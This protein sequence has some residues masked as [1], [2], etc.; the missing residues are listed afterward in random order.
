M[1]HQIAIE[2]VL[3]EK[4]LFEPDPA[5]ARRANVPGQAAYR[6]LR[7]EAETDYQRYW[8]RL[9][10]EHVDWFT[11]WKKVLDWKPPFAKWFVGAKTNISYNC[12]DRHLEGPNAW[13]RNKAAIIWE[14]E[15]GDQRVLTFGD[16]HRE[17][18]KCANVLKGLGVKK[19]DRVAIYMPM[20]PELAVAML[21]CTRIGAVHSII[22]GGFSADSIRDRVNDAKAKLVITADGGWRRGQIIPLKDTIDEALQ[23]A[24]S[25][26][27]VLVVQRTGQSIL[28]KNGR[29]QWWHDQMKTAS[30]DC[31]PAKLDAEHPLFILYTSGTTGKPK[32]I[33]H[34]TGGYLVHTTVTAKYIFDLKEEDTYWCT[35]DIGWVTGHSYVIYG[36]LS[37][38]VTSVMYEGAPNHPDVDRF[39]EIVDKYNVTILYTAPTAIR[40]FMKW[41]D[42]HVRKH[43]L[44]SLRLL[45]TVGEP[46]NP[47]AWIWYH[48]TLGKKRCPIVDTWWQTE[49]GGILITPLPGC[50][51][52]TP[53]SATLP[54]PGIFA[55]ILDEQGKPVGTNQG[56]YLVIT[57]PWPGMLRGIYGDRKRYKEQY[58]SKYKGIYLTG[59]GARKDK[60]GY[61]WI[62]GR[63][64]DVMNVAGHRLS[65]MEIESA[66]VSHPEV[67]EAAVVGR[68]DEIKGTAIVGFVTL[69]QGNEPSDALRQTLRQHVAKEIGAIARPD[70]IRFTES[71]PKTRSGKIMR[72]LLRDIA[73]GRGSVGDTTTLEDYSILAKLREAEEA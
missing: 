62:M 25:V 18:C 65:T 71:L 30:S 5:F 26:K 49:T 47:E 41:G 31:P 45:G 56:G 70:E 3:R 15:P 29:D 11:P 50:V 19:G 17:V 22:F 72:R 12:L 10:K 34:T 35:A 16:L 4:R 63:V 48:R 43:S 59:D 52:T 40:T 21:A 33:L 46:I 42:K 27:H 51:T 2:S 66:L 38:G 60:N 61:F 14:G 1:T 24:D 54:F 8:A 44:A 23:G 58:W 36:I 7:K 13:R 9:A 73:A 68:P 64:D 32:G 55:D 28:M 37:N 67:V 53:G 20:V 69:E 57:R 6:R 39:W